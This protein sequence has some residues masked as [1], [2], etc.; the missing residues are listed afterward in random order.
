MLS[1]ADVISRANEYAIRAAHEKEL[2]E[3]GDRGAFTAAVS[4]L[5]AEM[6]LREIALLL[7]EDEAAA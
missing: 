4:F 6:V 3:A 7:T 1:A 2:A 5:T